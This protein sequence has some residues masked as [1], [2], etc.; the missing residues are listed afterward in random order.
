MRNTPP[1]SSS[2]IRP[3]KNT[4]CE[5]PRHLIYAIIILG[6]F[7][8]VGQCRQIYEWRKKYSTFRFYGDASTLGYKYEIWQ[9]RG[10][11]ASLNN[12]KTKQTSDKCG[13]VYICHR[14]NSIVAGPSPLLQRYYCSHK[15]AA[16]G[17]HCVLGTG[18][19]TG[20]LS[21]PKMI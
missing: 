8:H 16:M 21:I 12:Q 4:N 19:L 3:V 13:C 2:L 11:K 15:I 17:L 9:S 20:P 18:P 10:I 14:Y 7:C 6:H 5:A 1:I